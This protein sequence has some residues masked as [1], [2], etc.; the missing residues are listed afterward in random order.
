MRFLVVEHRLYEI[1]ADNIQEA[2]ELF[3]EHGPEISVEE[4]VIDRGLTRR[5]W[6]SEMKIG[7]A[8]DRSSSTGNIER[9]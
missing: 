7:V 8:P 1:Y 3:D 5:T 4:P 2:Q 6:R 9:K